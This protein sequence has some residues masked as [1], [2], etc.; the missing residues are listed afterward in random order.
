MKDL[1]S[2][3]HYCYKIRTPLMKSSAPPSIDTPLPPILNTLPIFIQQNFDLPLLWFFK[4]LNS[5]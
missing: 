2:K 3:E 4:N 1:L 5:L